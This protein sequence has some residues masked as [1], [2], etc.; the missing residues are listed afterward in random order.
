MDELLEFAK[1]IRASEDANLYTI[2]DLVDLKDDVMADVR[3][4]AAGEMDKELLLEREYAGFYITEHPISAYKE[5]LDKAKRMM[6]SDLIDEIELIKES[7]NILEY[8][9]RN[10][11]KIAGV[12]R[13]VNT[14][15]TKKTGDPLNVFT[16]E[17]EA[18][19]MRC[20]AFSDVIDRNKA[21]FTE[22]QL[23]YLE[24]TIRSDDR[25]TQMTVRTI[26]DVHDL[27]HF[28]HPIAYELKGSEVVEQAREQ[29]REVKQLQNDFYL[30]RFE[31]G[32]VLTFIQE[33]QKFNMPFVVPD[34]MNVQIALKKI[35]GEENV[36]AIYE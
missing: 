33:G 25:E 4:Q 35:M 14:Y 30:E 3:I 16:V 19:E 32:V 9:S 15:Y 22:G 20:V 36:Q 31:S 5:D 2:F 18:G 28:L 1:M 34:G 27:K 17:D 24:G 26:A 8:E 12:I 29:Y 7:R 10:T 13:E 21:L 11:F 23:V 6:T